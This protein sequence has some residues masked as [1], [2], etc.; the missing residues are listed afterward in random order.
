M[1]E[2]G[3][4][5][6]AEADH[7]SNTLE[8]LSSIAPFNTMSPGLLAKVAAAATDRHLHR[9]E[10]LIQEG[11]NGTSLFVVMSGRLRAYVQDGN[12]TNVVVGEISAGEAVGEMALLSDQPRSASVL[13]IRESRLIELS[14]DA[15]HNLIETEPAALTS[16]ARTI[17]ERLGRSIHGS[18]GAGRVRTIALVPAGETANLRQVAEDLAAELSTR[19]SVATVD[20]DHFTR[21]TD[22]PADGGKVSFSRWI[23]E[24]EGQYDK[25]LLI[26]DPASDDWTHGCIGQADRILLIGDPTSSPRLNRIEVDLL[27]QIDHD[28]HARIDLIMIHDGNRHLPLPIEP[29]LRERPGIRSFNLKPDSAIGY[30][31]LARILVGEAVNLVLS[32]GGARGLAHIGVVKALEE[33]S[34]PI[35]VV[36]GASFGSITAGSIA[37]GRS[38]EE[39]REATLQHLLGSG[40]PVDLT[41]PLI[42]LARGAKVRHQLQGG[43]G[44]TTIENLWLGFF[45]VSSNLTRGEVKVHQSGPLWQAIRASIS[46]PGIF[47]P[48]RSPDGDVLVDGAVMN[49]LPVDVMQALGESGPMLAVNLRSSVDMAAHDLPH[50]G[51]VSGWQ[52]LRKRVAPWRRASAMPGIAEILLRTSEI[53]S[54]ISSKT[55]ESRADLVFRPPVGEFALMDF[56]AIDDLIEVGYRHAID[57]LEHSAQHVVRSGLPLERRESGRQ[58]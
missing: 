9:G 35:D 39:T 51:A 13:A 25:I 55:F 15:F 2:H 18:V 36:G 33:A 50:D 20:Q 30:P 19:G 23:Q 14:R 28:R 48:V 46:I 40:S 11:D 53:G 52:T 22:M 8:L 24:L 32:G 43:F 47:A 21:S 7:R 5:P 17:V 45:C 10:I 37:M 3:R 49:N 4:G 57:V 1:R 31:R 12:G 27:T 26:G 41:V 29:W 58:T 38:W 44:E 54:V 34:I 6:I 16:L 42:A 56:S